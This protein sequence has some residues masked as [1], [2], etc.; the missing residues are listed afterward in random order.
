[1]GLGLGYKMGVVA[2]L[3]NFLSKFLSQHMKNA[4][5][6][7]HDERRF[8]N[9]VFPGCFSATSACNFHKNST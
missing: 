4:L 6:H 8:H 9:L 3:I 1:M 5:G 7:C 2:I